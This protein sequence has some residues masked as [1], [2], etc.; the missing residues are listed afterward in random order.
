[1]NAWLLLLA[2]GLL[3]IIWATGLRFTDGFSR[4]LPTV[5]V[6]VIAWLSFYL[7]AVAMRDIPM[8]TAYAIW[9][10]I[11]ATGVAMIGILWFKEPASLARLGFIAMIVIGIIGLKWSSG[12]H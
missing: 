10:G 4:L 7:L 3:E 1:M 8:G 2:A 9:T 6:L 5:A 12:N 11:G